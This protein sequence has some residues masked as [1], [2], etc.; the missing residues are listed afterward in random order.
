MTG[1][2]MFR[3][4]LDIVSNSFHLLFIS[5]YSVA[6]IAIFAVLGGSVLVYIVRWLSRAR[7]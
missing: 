5:K 6:F 2:D 3:E 7:F 1:F 4:F